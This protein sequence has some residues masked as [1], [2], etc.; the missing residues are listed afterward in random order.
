MLRD[1]TEALVYLARRENHRAGYHARLMLVAALYSAGSSRVTI[2]V[3][4][5]AD[6]PSDGI[7][8]YLPSASQSTRAIERVLEE[9]I[10]KG[11]IKPDVRQRGSAVRLYWRKAT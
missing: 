11:T 6:A 9:A 8:V 3:D 4:E 2:G 1:P 5:D 7:L 10:R